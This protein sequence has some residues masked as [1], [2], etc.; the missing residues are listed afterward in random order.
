MDQIE[1]YDHFVDLITQETQKVGY[2]ISQ[3]ILKKINK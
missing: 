3:D 2:E 1:N